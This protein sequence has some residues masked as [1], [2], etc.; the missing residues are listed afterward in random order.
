MQR[1][2]LEWMNEVSMTPNYVNPKFEVQEFKLNEEVE[3]ESLAD[4][5]GASHTERGINGSVIKSAADHSGE[6]QV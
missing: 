6:N 5:D 2:I 4:Q 1:T 3:E